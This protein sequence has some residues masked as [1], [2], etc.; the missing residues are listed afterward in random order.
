MSNAP[1][2]GIAQLP[3][4]VRRTMPVP[5]VQPHRTPALLPRIPRHDDDSSHSRSPTKRH[6]PATNTFIRSP[7]HEPLGAAV[8]RVPGDRLLQRLQWQLLHVHSRGT[9]PA[10]DPAGEHVGGERAIRE[11][12][13]RHTHISDVGHVKTVRGRRLK[14]PVARSGL[15][16]A[17]PT[18]FVVTSVLPRLTPCMPSPRMIPITRSRP[19]SLGF[20]PRAISWAW[21]LRYPYTSMKTSLWI[22][23]MS[24]ANVSWQ[25]TMRL[26]NGFKHA[27]VAQRDEPA[28]QRSG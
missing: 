12:S 28:I 17:P 19:T 16:P 11:A 22:V 24:H 21:T 15:S 23:R 18:G 7:T 6:H 3:D 2:A 5:L 25:A 26:G 13:A 4:H 10:D 8:P 20:Q 9:R 1:L 27:T 14:L